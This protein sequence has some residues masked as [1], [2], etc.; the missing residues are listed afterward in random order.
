MAVAYFQKI[1]LLSVLAGSAERD[2]CQICAKSSTCRLSDLWHSRQVRPPPPP[3]NQDLKIQCTNISEVC[4]CECVWAAQL[5][6]LRHLGLEVC[7]CEVDQRFRGEIIMR[8]NLLNIF[9]H[10]V[11]NQDLATHKG[12]RRETQFNSR[13]AEQSRAEQSRAGRQWKEMERPAF[14]DEKISAS[15]HIWLTT[16]GGLEN[17]VVYNIN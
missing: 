12:Q 10:E 16:F 2:V 3:I 6:F 11:T 1:S 8:L 17:K 13:T 4:P 14:H 15:K 7:S 9:F 5:S